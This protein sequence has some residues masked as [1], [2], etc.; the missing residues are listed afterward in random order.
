MEVDQSHRM[1]TKSV[2]PVVTTSNRLAVHSVSRTDAASYVQDVWAIS[3]SISLTGGVRYDQLSDF[4]NHPSYRA[5]LVADHHSYYGKLLYGTAFRVPS[6][7]EYLDKDSYNFSLRPEHL[8]TF[9]AQ[10]GRKFRR[11][12]LS[13]TFYDNRYT[14]LIKEILV[15]SI[16]TPTQVRVLGNEYSI[17]ADKSSIQGLELESKFIPFEGFNVVFGA[18]RILRAKEKIGN[19]D[20]SIIPSTT[21]ELRETDSTFLAKTTSS[22]L[23]SYRVPNGGHEFG[24]NATGISR[25]RTPA[26]YQSKV[27]AANVNLE[28]A[29]GFVR[30]D[31]FSSIHVSRQIGLGLK[32]Q[33]V[34]NGRHYSPP[35]DNITGYDSEWSGRTF[36][37]E[38]T[39]RK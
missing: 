6:Y 24:V 25:R 20:A 27:P 31:A 38:L 22:A 3:P 23:V 35:F 14:K 29:A 21:L 33:N 9:E 11:A 7:R 28:N 12:D 17:N 10:L 39:L 18:S 32:V 8:N 5:G 13:L 2:Y 36:R 16:V 4:Q 15:D 34:L 1:R 26:E 19:L 37:F 30:L